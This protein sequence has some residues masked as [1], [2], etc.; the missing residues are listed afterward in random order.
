MKSLKYYI[1]RIQEKLFTKTYYI[2]GDSHTEVFKHISEKKRLKLKRFDV[3]FVG[4]A[5]AQGMRNPNSKTNAL[6]EF[7]DKIYTL[8]KSSKLIFQLGEVDTGFVIW[9]RAKKYNEPVE[10]Q[11]MLSINSYVDFLKKIKKDGYNHIMVVSA[12]LPTIQDNQDW[13]EVA[14]LRKEVTATLRERT[15]LTLQYNKLLEEECKKHNVYFLPTDDLLLDEETKKIKSV[16]LN[17]DKN[18]H[19]L[20]LE[21]YSEVI[22]KRFDGNF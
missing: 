3:T 19:H 22:I 18:N 11:L 5:T 17:K 20:H 14:N 7:E 15:D 6:Q 2:F 12:P 10:E 13:G 1:Y 4:G 9:Y 16:F 21:A 8:K